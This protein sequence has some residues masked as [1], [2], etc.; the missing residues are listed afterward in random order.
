MYPNE[1]NAKMP[2]AMIAYSHIA[3]TASDDATVI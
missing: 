2:P 1:L 3:A